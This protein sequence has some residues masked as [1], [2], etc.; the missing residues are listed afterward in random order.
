MVKA[1]QKW[2]TLVKHHQVVVHG[3]QTVVK[4][5]WSSIVRLVR[6]VAQ[7]P[8]LAFPGTSQAVPFGV[9]LLF[10]TRSKVIR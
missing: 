1:H 4:L 6:R 5:C 10:Y 3:R 7:L 2:D 9:R 8:D